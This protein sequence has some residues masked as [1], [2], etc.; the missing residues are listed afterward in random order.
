M[1][2]ISSIFDTGTQKKAYIKVEETFYAVSSFLAVPRGKI[3]WR[4]NVSAQHR[5]A[6]DAAG[7]ARAL[8]AILKRDRVPMLVPVYGGCQRRN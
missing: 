4:V 7:A 5:R 8:G 2:K 6:V 3:L 1:L